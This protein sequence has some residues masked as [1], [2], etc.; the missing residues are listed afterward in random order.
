MAARPALASR[1]EARP[2]PAPSIIV[3]GASWG[4]LHALS[5]LVRDLPEQL[6][7]AVVIVQHRSRDSDTLLSRLLQDLTPLVVVEVDDKDSICPGHIYV[8]PPDYHLLVDGTYFSLSTDPLVRYSRPSID[9]TFLTAAD[10]FR[11]RTVGV[12]LTGANEDGAQGLARIAALGGKTV[13]QDP[14]TAEMPRM[15]NAALSAV[16]TA[17]VL[18]LG[19]IGAYVAGI[20]GVD[21]AATCREVT[22]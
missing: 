1:S 11:E 20:V 22:A 9:V 14:A 12:V 4:G 21:P 13:V 3:V 15:P 5:Q 16:P 8:A 10:T 17:K 18:A 7:A 2:R 6:A 19:A